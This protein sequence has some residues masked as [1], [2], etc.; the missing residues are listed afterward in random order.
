[1]SKSPDNKKDKEKLGKDYIPEKD[2]AEETINQI[3]VENS[4]NQN[5]PRTGRVD[6]PHIDDDIGTGTF[7]ADVA[8]QEGRF[9]DKVLMDSPSVEAGALG[10]DALKETIEASEEKL[11]KKMNDGEGKKERD[12]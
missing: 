10:H 4:P 9:R 12:K 2:L 11:A 8:Q 3:N 1:M 6:F 5:T 7:K